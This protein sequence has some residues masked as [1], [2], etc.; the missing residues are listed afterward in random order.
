MTEKG[1]GKIEDL[2]RK[3]FRSG[4]SLSYFIEM[5]GLSAVLH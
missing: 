1:I 4:Y 2:I 3:V 5:V